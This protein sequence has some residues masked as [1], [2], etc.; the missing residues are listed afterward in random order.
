MSFEEAN[1]CNLISMGIAIALVACRRIIFVT[2]FFMGLN[3][4]LNKVLF[5]PKSEDVLV[6]LNK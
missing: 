4:D 2:P 5:N 1:M 3:W 6:V